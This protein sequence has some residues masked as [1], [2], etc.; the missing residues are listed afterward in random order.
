MP[1]PARDIGPH[2]R[3]AYSC[4]LTQCVLRLPQAGLPRGSRPC[5]M[6]VRET[7]RA[8]ARFTGPIQGASDVQRVL[9]VTA[10][11][12]PSSGRLAAFAPSCRVWAVDATASDRCHAIVRAPGDASCPIASRQ[13]PER[14]DPRVFDAARPTPSLR[15][16]RSLRPTPAVRSGSG[17]PALRSVRR[18]ARR[19][20]SARFTAAEPRPDRI[21]D[22]TLHRRGWTLPTSRG[23]AALLRA[24]GP[25]NPAARQRRAG[26]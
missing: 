26:N 16:H 10:A 21:R 4:P 2:A 11:R 20:N 24:C 18:R 7:R 9:D 25:L 12:Q 17:R 5:S 6:R 19:M 15:R 14:R 1:T 22:G 13:L 8:C 3:V 23:P